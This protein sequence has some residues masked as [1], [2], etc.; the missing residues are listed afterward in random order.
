VEWIAIARGEVGGCKS[1]K[2]GVAACRR[3]KES[4]AGG[5]RMDLRDMVLGWG[6]EEFGTE[7]LQEVEG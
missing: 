6:K 4:V 5:E 1:G 7:G 3:G 2:E